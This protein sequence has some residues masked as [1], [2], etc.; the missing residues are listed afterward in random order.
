MRGRQKGIFGDK[1]IGH[2]GKFRQRCSRAFSQTCKCFSTYA[3]SNR[4]GFGMVEM[5]EERK[6]RFAGLGRQK[7]IF[8]D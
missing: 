2:A 6:K 3:G 5:G 7:G 4:G 1:G 8:G